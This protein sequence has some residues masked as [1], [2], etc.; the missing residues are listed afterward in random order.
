M[1]SVTHPGHAWGLLNARLF[2]QIMDSDKPRGDDVA[3]IGRN[4]GALPA[5]HEVRATQEPGS[6]TNNILAIDTDAATRLLSALQRVAGTIHDQLHDTI[7]GDT[8]E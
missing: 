8:G 5:V 6:V 1:P 3:T 4:M 2:S 7:D